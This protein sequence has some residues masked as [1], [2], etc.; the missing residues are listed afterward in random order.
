MP[1]L[2]LRFISGKYK[3]GEYILS[4]SKE[5]Y[6]GRRS[7]IDLVL[8]EDMVSRKHARIRIEQGEIQIKDLGSTNGTFVNEAE[9]TPKARVGLKDGDAISMGDVEATFHLGG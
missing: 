9:V 8:M 3:G 5:I 1:R 4:V 7:D 2:A 6:V